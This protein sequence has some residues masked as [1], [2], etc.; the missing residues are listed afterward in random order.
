MYITGK[1]HNYTPSCMWYVSQDA[2]THKP[3]HLS[4]KE[5][6]LA[7]LMMLTGICLLMRESELAA[8]LQG[9]ERGNSF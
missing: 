6:I 7:N 8:G 1:N 9:E 4:L 3:R 2:L 5:R